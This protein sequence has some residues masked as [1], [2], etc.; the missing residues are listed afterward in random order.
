MHPDLEYPAMSV[1][2]PAKPLLPSDM[3]FHYLLYRAARSDS[4]RRGNDCL[5]D[6]LGIR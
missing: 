2:C 5:I 3:P 1:R 4:R 6:A